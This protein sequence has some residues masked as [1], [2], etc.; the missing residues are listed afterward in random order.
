[1]SGLRGGGLVLLR[2]QE[3]LVSVLELTGAGHMFTIWAD[4]SP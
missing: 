2:P 4:Q 1:M 3:Q